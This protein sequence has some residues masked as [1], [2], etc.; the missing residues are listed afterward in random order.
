[1]SKYPLNYNKFILCYRDILRDFLLRGIENVENDI[2]KETTAQVVKEVKTRIV[3]LEPEKE[4][5]KILLE[6]WNLVPLDDSVDPYPF[7]KFNPPRERFIR[8]INPM[9]IPP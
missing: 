1:F 8:D 6:L 3:K 7:K 4:L 9:F 5:T 2:N